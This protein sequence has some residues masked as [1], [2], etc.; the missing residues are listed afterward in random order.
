MPYSSVGRHESP[1]STKTAASSPTKV[2]ATETS[3]AGRLGGVAARQDG[4]ESAATG[5][6]D[7][8]HSAGVGLDDAVDDGQTQSGAGGRA[9][10]VHWGAGCGSAPDGVE[11]AAE[12]LADAPA[13]IADSEQPPPMNISR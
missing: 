9:G 12:V 2:T 1:R 3:S 10:T 5:H 6:V 13:L 11:D 7:H 4:V 8:A